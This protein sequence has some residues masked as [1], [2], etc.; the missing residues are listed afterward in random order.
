M[1]Q[2]QCK[3]CGAAVSESTT[4]CMNCGS[5]EFVSIQQQAQQSAWGAQQQQAQQ[6]AWGAQQQQA[7]QPAWGAQQQQAQQPAWGAQQ[8]QAQ[9]PAWGAQQQQAQQPVWGAQ[10][11]QADFAPAYAQAGAAAEKKGLKPWQIAV[12]AGAVLLILLIVI[13]AAMSGGSDGGPGGAGLDNNGVSNNIQSGF[14]SDEHAGNKAYESKTV[15]IYMVG[16]DLESKNYCATS[17]IVEMAESKVDTTDNK[18]LICAGGTAGWYNDWLPP[19]KNNILILKDDDVEI[20]RQ[21]PEKSM[22]DGDTLSEFVKYCM[23]EYPSDQYGLI[24]WNHGGGPMDGYGWDQDSN[25]LMSISELADALGEAGLGD[26]QKL[27]FIGFDACLMGTIETAWELRDYAEYMIASQE[28]EPGSGWDYKCLKLLDHYDDGKDIG[29]GIVDAYMSTLEKAFAE[30]PEIRC[31]ITLSCVDLSEIEDVER[32]M[33][34]LFEKAEAG[35]RSGNFANASR[36]R[37]NAKAFGRFNSG[38]EY[39]LVDMVHLVSLMSADYP[40]EAEQLIGELKEYVCYSRS[41]VANASG[42]SIYHPLDNRAEMTAW[43]RMFG[44]FDFSE[45]YTRYISG[46]SNMLSEPGALSWKGFGATKGNAVKSGVNNELSITLTAEQAE[47]YAGSSYYILR[48]LNNDEYLFVFAGF[49]AS[50]SSGGV[51]SATYNNKAVFAVDEKTNKASDFPITMYQVRDGSNEQKYIASAMFWSFAGE[52]SDWKTDP[53]EWQVRI[54][55]GVPSLHSAY[56]IENAEVPAKQM[57]NYKDYDT[58]EFSFSTRKPKQ[59]ANGNL[60]PYFEWDSTGNFYGHQYEVKDGFHLECREIENKND[61]YV[62]FV[63][64]DIRGNSYASDMFTLPG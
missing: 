42:V 41:N 12:I 2:K 40:A 62:M 56:L 4:F 34:V 16:S 37:H 28:T 54:D 44:S 3:K 38:R 11:Q 58:I 1:S 48:K 31:E 7:Q 64:Y 29:K 23:D 36:A 32:S 49:D 10:Q 60:L 27:E 9:Q 46:F 8:Q 15:M 51:L 61:Y 30:H 63:V 14:S 18:I 13:I 57:L 53:V 59:D 43:T 20:V 33:D 50:L 21:T 17:D 19:D 55:G 26:G 5:S 25:D 39:D 45:N 52:I 6:S 22:A 24:L 35:I 47:N